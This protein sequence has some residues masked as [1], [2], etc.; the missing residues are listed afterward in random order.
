MVVNTDMVHLDLW[1]TYKQEKAQS[2][3]ALILGAIAGGLAF[4]VT[5]LVNSY[6]NHL[7][8]WTLGFAVSSFTGAYMDQSQSTADFFC[9]LYP[10]S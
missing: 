6:Y 5:L 10:G 3:T 2:Q 8:G 9:R 7:I 4:A 1:C